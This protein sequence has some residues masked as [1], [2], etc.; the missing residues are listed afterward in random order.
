MLIENPGDGLSPSE[1]RSQSLDGEQLI[2]RRGIF[3]VQKL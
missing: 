1:I 2:P 3:W